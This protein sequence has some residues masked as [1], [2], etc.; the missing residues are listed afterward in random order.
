MQGNL[1]GVNLSHF[2]QSE[3]KINDKEYL[4]SNK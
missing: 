4:K 2:E 1:R 3:N